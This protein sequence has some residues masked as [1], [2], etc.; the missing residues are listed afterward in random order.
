VPA[1]A[2]HDS[3][4]YGDCKRVWIRNAEAKAEWS[5]RAESRSFNV[6]SRLSASGLRQFAIEQPHNDVIMPPSIYPSGFPL[7]TLDNE[8]TLLVRTNGS[9]IIGK[10]TY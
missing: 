10:H 5:G 2:P 4:A 6:G 3:H 1:L 9:M 7:M 8:A